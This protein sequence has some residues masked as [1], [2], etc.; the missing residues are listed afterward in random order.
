VYNNCH[1]TT[2]IHTTL[3]I[4]VGLPTPYNTILSLSYSIL[5]HPPPSCAWSHLTAQLRKRERERE[6]R[7][8]EE[9]KERELYKLRF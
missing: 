8:R 5:Q 1:P 6:R 3:L 7:E 9:R 4:N 2:T